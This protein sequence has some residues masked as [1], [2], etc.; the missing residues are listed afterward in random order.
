MC[1]FTNRQ[2]VQKANWHCKR[3]HQTLGKTY[4]FDKKEHDERINKKDKK[5]TLEKYNKQILYMTVII[6]FTNIIILK[7]MIALLLNQSIPF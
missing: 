2:W 4:E 1:I 5:L 7:D 6:V 3:Q